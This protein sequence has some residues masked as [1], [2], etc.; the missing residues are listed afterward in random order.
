MR[1]VLPVIKPVRSAVIRGQRWKYKRVSPSRCVV[2]GEKV[3]G[4]CDYDNSVLVVRN[5]LQGE[6]LMEVVIHEFLHAALP[7]LNA[8][9]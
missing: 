8:A 9:L 2:K 3:R 7:D 4:Y 6:E 5:D 1:G